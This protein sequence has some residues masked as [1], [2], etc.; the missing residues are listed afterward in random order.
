MAA[1]QQ[2]A[3]N[4]PRSFIICIYYSV[5]YRFVTY[6]AE[7]R[8]AASARDLAKGAL[9]RKALIAFFSVLLMQPLFLQ[10]VS[11]QVPQAP[12]ST[13]GPAYRINAGDEIEVELTPVATDLRSS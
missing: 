12:R 4:G 13:A 8:G 3:K 11:A 9:V 10:S 1:K 7:Q 6:H 2:A 5:S